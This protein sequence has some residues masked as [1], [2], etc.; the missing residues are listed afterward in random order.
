M[1]YWVETTML[2]AGDP[3]DR[4][5]VVVVGVPDGPGGT[6]TVVSRS[7]ADGFGVEHPADPGLG[8]ATAGHFSRAHP[9]QAGTWTAGDVT[10]IGPLDPATLAAVRHRFTP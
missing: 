6:V 3:E 2:P 7:T 1:V 10:P 4:R 8:L 5:P 9:V